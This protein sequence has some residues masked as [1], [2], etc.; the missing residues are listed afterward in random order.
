M[1]RRASLAVALAVAAVTS[2]FASPSGAHAEAPLLVMLD[3]ARRDALAPALAVELA[4]REAELLIVDPP[5]GAT[6]LARAASAQ[7]ACRFV[8]GIAAV[9]VDDGTV[10]LVGPDGDA[11]RHAPLPA[12]YETIDP[13][14]FAVV[15]HSLL[16]E[17]VGPPDPPIR[18][19]VAIDAPGREVT[20]AR[21]VP[22]ENGGATAEVHVDRSPSELTAPPA[23][24]P[25]PA[26]PAAPALR[27]A[28]GTAEPKREDALLVDEGEDDTPLL[29]REGL[30]IEGS[31]LFAGLAA[32]GALGLGWQLHEDFRLS[33]AMNAVAVLADGGG[34]A[35]MPQVSLTRVGSSRS[36]RFD[37]GAQAGLLF[38]EEPY[39]ETLAS[40]SRP[41]PSDE[42]IED[43]TTY[44]SSVTRVGWTV[45]GFFGWTWE[46]DDW[47]ALGVRLSLQ[48][49]SV[50]DSG[51]ILAP[52][53]SM[54][55]ELPI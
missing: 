26:P 6:P 41:I 32:G 45:G 31:A 2:A 51:P 35:Y 3:P 53:L 13:R 55:T 9:Y 21:V 38:I 8:G 39:V 44:A 4:S 24:P 7:E 50:E 40:G 27:A 20:L 25:T 12:P 49:A 5:E 47:L 48:V 28:R 54:H 17:L 23:P 33:V 43:T 15:A 16:A 10:R 14:I 11:I 46:L 30:F 42:T 52:M 22:A 36:G 29:P 19:T 34:A 1:P 18:V 37:F